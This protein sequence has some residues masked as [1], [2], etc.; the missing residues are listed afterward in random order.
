VTP[1]PDPTK[2]EP[3]EVV[4]VK[5]VAALGAQQVYDEAVAAEQALRDRHT[6]LRSAR[7]EVKRLDERIER[8]E[9]ELVEQHRPDYKTQAEFERAFKGITLNDPDLIAIRSQRD[10][11]QSSQHEMEHA[12]REAELTIK[13]RSARMTELGGILSFYGSVKMLRAAASTPDTPDT[14]EN[15]DDPR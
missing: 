1:V 5:A 7:N 3:P 8:R 2:P 11:A 15:R 10:E 6:V 4:A 13:I 14:P 9:F 12:I